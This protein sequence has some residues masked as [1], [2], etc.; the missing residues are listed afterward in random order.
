MSK[1]IKP[2][3]ISYTKVNSYVSLIGPAPCMFFYILFEEPLQSMEDILIKYNI[4]KFEG[5]YYL[6]LL[7][8]AKLV[9]ILVVGEEIHYQLFKPIKLNG[10]SG[11][12]WNQISRQKLEV[13]SGSNI[14]KT[15][16]DIFGLKDK[17]KIQENNTTWVAN[18]EK[19]TSS[20]I[21]ISSLMAINKVQT[22]NDFD[23]SII[24]IMLD[25]T[26]EKCQK[27]NIKYFNLVTKTF[28]KLNIKNSTEAKDFFDNQLFNQSDNSEKYLMDLKAELKAMEE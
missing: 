3:S 23:D 9:Q 5:H 8:A 26:F 6:D 20:K 17:Q 2:T 27:F 15:Y 4:K 1:F 13:S 7:Q 25:R 16:N 14:S 18:F 22:E 24:N 21:D 12:K 11:E 19:H 10:S 28:N